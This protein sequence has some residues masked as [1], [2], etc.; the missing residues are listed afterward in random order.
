M[1]SVSFTAE[2]AFNRVQ[3]LRQWLLWLPAAILRGDDS[4][5]IGLAI[6]A[7]LLTIAVDL[8]YLFAELGDYESRL[9]S[10][11]PIG[12]YQTIYTRGAAASSSPDMQLAMSLMKPPRCLTARFEDYFQQSPNTCMP[13]HATLH[14]SNQ[15]FSS[16]SD[17]ASVPEVLRNYCSFLDQTADHLETWWAISPP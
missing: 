3:P 5:T 10:V 15:E 7:Q 1:L 11:G 14:V 13:S 6:L 12:I 17:Y 9:L 4:D 8:D 16:S 2:E